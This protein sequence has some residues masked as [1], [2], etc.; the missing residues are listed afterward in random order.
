MQLSLITQTKSMLLSHTKE[1]VSIH[2]LLLNRGQETLSNHL[3]QPF[4]KWIRAHRQLLRT[5]KS[6]LL[7]KTAT[8]FRKKEF[9]AKLR[10]Q[11]LCEKPFL[12]INQVMNPRRKVP[13]HSKGKMLIH[14]Q[15]QHRRKVVVAKLQAIFHKLL[16]ASLLRSNR[17]FKLRIRSMECY[18]FRIPCRKSNRLNPYLIRIFKVSNSLNDRICNHLTSK[19]HQL[20][21]TP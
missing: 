7:V 21:K 14:L 19:C 18:N 11:V 13:M 12:A 10:N 3:F 16:Q 9:L 8:I 17:V 20:V 2:H 15:L 4:K 5:M 1:E 6:A